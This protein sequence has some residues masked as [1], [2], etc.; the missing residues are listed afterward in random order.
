LCIQGQKAEWLFRYNQRQEAE[1]LLGYPQGQ[2]QDEFF[3]I[4][5]SIWER[6]RD[7]SV[8]ISRDRRRNVT[9]GISRDRRQDVSF[10]MQYLVPVRGKNRVAGIIDLWYSYDGILICG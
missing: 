9:F 1:C 10:G 6:R 2:T 8:G 3:G 5:Y 4:Q 7:V